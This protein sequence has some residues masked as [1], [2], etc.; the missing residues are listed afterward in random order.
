MNVFRCSSIVLI[1]FSCLCLIYL[2]GCAS[3]SKGVVEGLVSKKENEVDTRKCE[4]QGPTITGISEH[5]KI[6]GLEDKKPLPLA[7]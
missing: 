3:I 5:F 2:S 7:V 1:L 4:I 6:D